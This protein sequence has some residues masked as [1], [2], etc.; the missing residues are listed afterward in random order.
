GLLPALRATRTDPV[1]GLRDQGRGVAGSATWLRVGRAVVIGQLALSLPLLVGAGLLARTLVNLQRV[2]LGYSKEDVVTVRVDAQ[3]A[4]YD[5]ARR[6]IAF[7]ELLARIRALP[8]V[9]AA[10][11]SNNGL[12]GG[13]D[14]GDQIVVEGYTP[15]GNGDGGSRY[16]A[17]GPG[18]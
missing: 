16:N 6:L 17:V 5:A 2:D 1:R 9:R 18:Y 15:K 13:S 12:F 8:G 3:S 14:N 4:G 7:D 11:Y 10:T